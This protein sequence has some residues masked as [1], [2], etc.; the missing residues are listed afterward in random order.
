MAA[1]NPFPVGG[2]VFTLDCSLNRMT[3]FVKSARVSQLL[4]ALFWI[5]VWLPGNEPSCV[6]PIGYLQP[7]KYTP[8][9]SDSF[10]ALLI[11]LVWFL[12]RP[13]RSRVF[14]QYSVP[15]RLTHVSTFKSTGNDSSCFKKKPPYKCWQVHPFTCQLLVCCD[16]LLFSGQNQYLHLSCSNLGSPA[17][18]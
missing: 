6:P 3:F 15:F 9:P 16:C 13:P 2:L 18:T 12:P 4:L 11:S 1:A 17:L 8:H 14:R 7:A 10:A 5:T